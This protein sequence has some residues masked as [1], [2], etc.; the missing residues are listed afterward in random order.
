MMT[1]GDCNG[2]PG[3]MDRRRRTARFAVTERVW[4]RVVTVWEH[5]SDFDIKALL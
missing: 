1:R 2:T 5:P 3:R 4:W